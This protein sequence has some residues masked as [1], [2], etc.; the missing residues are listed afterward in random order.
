M[1]LHPMGILH[2]DLMPAN[3]DLG[4]AYLQNKTGLTSGFQ[5]DRPERPPAHTSVHFEHRSAKPYN[6]LIPGPTFPKQ[7]HR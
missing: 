4:V 5:Y 7:L 6:S 1:G 2:R 3:P